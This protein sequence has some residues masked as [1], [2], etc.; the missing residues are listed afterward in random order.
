MSDASCKGEFP[1]TVEWM[2]VM[3]VVI[4]HVWFYP[5]SSQNDSLSDQEDHRPGFSMPS[6]SSFDAQ[7]TDTS[8]QAPSKFSMYNSVSQKL[9][10]SI[11]YMFHSCLSLHMWD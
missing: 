5:D 6:I 4:V 8:T 3:I 10:V 9:M 7:D 11:L 1:H 2:S